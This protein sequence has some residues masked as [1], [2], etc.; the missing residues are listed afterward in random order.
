MRRPESTLH[1]PSL[2]AP[3]NALAGLLL[4]VTLALLAPGCG[5][6]KS[7][8]GSGQLT[9]ADGRVVASVRL[10]G[11]PYQMG[12]W[13]GH[14][15]RERI[16]ERVAQARGI[17]PADFVE[18]FADQALHRLSE[19]LRQELDGMAAATGVEPIDLMR[20][21]VATE[22][23]RFKGAEA[24][25]QGMAGIGPRDGGFEARMRY[26]GSGRVRFARQAVVITRYPE[27]GPSSISLAPAGSLGAWAYVNLAGRGYVIA[28]VTM[29]DGRRMGFGGG[30]PLPLAAREAME[31][32]QDVEQ[33]EAELVGTMGHSGLGFSFHPGELPALRAMGGVQ[34]YTSP[35]VPW[36]LGD[37][38][39]L[40]VGPF[41]DP[42]N[43]EAKALQTQLVEPPEHTLEER[44]LR[45]Y[46]L[47]PQPE[48]A[49][50]VAV[51]KGSAGSVTLRFEVGS[52]ART[53]TLERKQ[54]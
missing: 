49:A 8:G 47:G 38:P 52:A 45:M 39:F 25:L 20:T 37:A 51:I 10:A 9:P 48:V 30:R 34:V 23:L 12:W 40:V 17:Q 3:Q 31:A 41:D 5:R 24:T 35:D 19:R 46:A 18:A 44:F 28:E 1:G 6:G 14:L 43:P 53:V 54:R 16:L 33:F 7:P 29:T 15:L 4:L 13:H 11:T 2:R 22:L 32:H 36:S 26:V 27:D 42:E 21:E 50:P